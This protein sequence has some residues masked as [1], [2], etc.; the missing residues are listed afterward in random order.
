M[1]VTAEAEA[2]TAFLCRATMWSTGQTTWTWIMSG[3]FAASN[4]NSP[5]RH[6]PPTF[7]TPS[8]PGSI[9]GIPVICVDS[10]GTRHTALTDGVVL[11][12][13]S[14]PVPKDSVWLVTGGGHAVVEVPEVQ[15]RS[16]LCAGNYQLVSP[17]VDHQHRAV[18]VL[19]RGGPRTVG[20]IEYIVFS[21][22]SDEGRECAA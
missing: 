5:C 9:S 10:T 4:L 8:L 13:Q 12:S 14:H 19:L 17:P 7:A 1:A 22:L 15:F 3:T 21:E 6:R 16:E 11:T 18:N 20:N 2:V